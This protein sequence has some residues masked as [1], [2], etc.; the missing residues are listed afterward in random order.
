MWQKINLWW[1]S[2]Q[3]HSFEK[4]KILSVA[5]IIGNEQ[6][7]VSE[8]SLHWPWLSLLVNSHCTQTNESPQALIKVSLSWSPSKQL[9]TRRLTCHKSHVSRSFLVLNYF[10]FFFWRSTSRTSLQVIVFILQCFYFSF[11]FK[12]ICS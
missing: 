1:E 3:P 10:F 2:K 12:Y 11:H 9:E 7:Q 6:I 8:Q 5:E 4:V